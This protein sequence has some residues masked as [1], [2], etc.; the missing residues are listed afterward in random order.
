MLILII[1]AIIGLTIFIAIARLFIEA[2]PYAMGLI[3]LLFAASF[4]YRNWATISG[5]LG[6]GIIIVVVVAVISMIADAG[7]RGNS[8]T[9]DTKDD[10]NKTYIKEMDKTAEAEVISGENKGLRM[11]FRNGDIHTCGS[12]QD[13]SLIFRNS[14]FIS[15]NHCKLSYGSNGQ[16]ILEDY[17]TNGT[18]VNGEIINKTKK[19]LKTG[20]KINLANTDNIILIKK[21]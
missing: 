3:L 7:G 18:Y 15:R 20:D 17:S 2:L 19:I 1:L 10:P 8:N 6:I 21:A 16:I 9:T 11:T 13:S 5:V 14:R 4:V 12:S